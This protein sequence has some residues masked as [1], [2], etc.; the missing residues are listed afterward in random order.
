VGVFKSSCNWRK[1]QGKDPGVLQRGYPR[2]KVPE[3]ERNHTWADDKEDELRMAAKAGGWD[4]GK[5][6]RAGKQ[7]C[8]QNYEGREL[9]G[10]RNRRRYASR[11]PGWSWKRLD[12]KK[13][14]SDGCAKG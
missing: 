1:G 7:R 11:Y 13:L 4:R 8:S 6:G 12:D 14:F 3:G 9:L 2:L 5:K 10:T